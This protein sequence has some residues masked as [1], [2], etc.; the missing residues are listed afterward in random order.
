MG[1]AFRRRL[2][3]SRAVSSSK[4]LAA[5][6]R[7][8]S[9]GCESSGGAVWPASPAGHG[10]FCQS[11]KS[12]RTPASFSSKRSIA[13]STAFTTARAA[14][15]GTAASKSLLSTLRSPPSAVVLRRTGLLS[16]F[17]SPPSPLAASP[18]WSCGQ[19]SVV[20]LLLSAFQLF[21]RPPFPSLPSR[22]QTIGTAGSTSGTGRPSFGVRTSQPAPRTPSP[23]P[24]SR[25]PHFCFLFSARPP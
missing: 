19:W 15:P 4:T 16:A 10:L 9:S 5:R 13:V 20:P 6:L 3:G 1:G 24:R 14:T 18:P 17:P 2:P 21:P 7:F 8:G 25:L 11:A 23:P 22:R 12:F